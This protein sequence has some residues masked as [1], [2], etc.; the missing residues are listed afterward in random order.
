MKILVLSDSHSSLSYM[1]LCIEA[2]KPDIMIHLGDY[3][4]DA[5][6]IAEEYAIASASS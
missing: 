2:V 3:Y 5:E 4:D 6:A 1:R